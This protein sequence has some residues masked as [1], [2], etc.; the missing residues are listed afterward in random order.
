MERGQGGG[1]KASRGGFRH[2]A[3]KR[4]VL[5]DAERA[6]LDDAIEFTQRIANA[7]KAFGIVIAR[8]QGGCLALDRDPKHE[9][10]LDIGDAAEW[11]VIVDVVRRTSND[12]RTRALAR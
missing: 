1:K 4:D 5:L 12:E 2:R 11:R 10:A 8:C 6:L 9:T 7:A 3:M